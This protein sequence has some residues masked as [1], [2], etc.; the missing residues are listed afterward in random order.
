LDGI[1]QLAHRALAIHCKHSLKVPKRDEDHP[2]EQHGYN[3]AEQKRKP[4]GFSYQGYKFF[5]EN[6][7]SPWIMSHRNKT[8]S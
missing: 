7:M 5:S 1:P 2:V 8:Q 3:T 4:T 6:S